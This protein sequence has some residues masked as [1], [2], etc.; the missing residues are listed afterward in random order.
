MFIPS[1]AALQNLVAESAHDFGL[2]TS[3]D[4]RPEHCNVAHVTLSVSGT[5]STQNHSAEPL[6]RNSRIPF[7]KSVQKCSVNLWPLIYRD[8]D[9][10]DIDLSKVIFER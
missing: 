7:N 4:G 2:C 3:I 5:F 6:V 9:Y 1:T 10:R 8:I